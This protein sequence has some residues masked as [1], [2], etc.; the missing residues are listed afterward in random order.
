MSELKTIILSTF[1]I[2]LVGCTSAP[3]VDIAGLESRANA[4]DPQAQNDLGSHYQ[5]GDGVEINYAKALM[6]YEKASNQGLPLATANLG[7]MYDL[8]LGANEDDT[9]AV[10]LYNS[11]AEAGS[12]RGMV[13]LGSM[14][15]AG[16]GVEK[17][18]VQA[19]KWFDTARFLTQQSSDMDAKWSSRGALDELSKFMS[20]EQIAEAK[21]LSK[22]WL[23][24]Q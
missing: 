24:K 20:P 9:K 21:A 23:S 5:F 14:Y 17:D 7:Y 10:E 4:G 11:A 8:G 1:F 12:P 6:W 3:K 13:N 18:Y 22:E 15:A 16:T 19:Y 2:V